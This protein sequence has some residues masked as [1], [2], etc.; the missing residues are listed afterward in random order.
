MAQFDPINPF[1]SPNDSTLD[2]Y[3][4]G[5]INNDNVIDIGDVNRLDSIIRGYLL[6]IQDDR[7]HDRSDINGDQEL[8]DQDFRLLEEY[9]AGISVYLPS[10]WNSLKTR[11][12]RIYWLKKMISIDKTNEHTNPVN[13]FGDYYTAQVVINFHGYEEQTLEYFAE[14]AIDVDQNGRFNL[15][16]FYA[17][18]GYNRPD[19]NLTRQRVSIIVGDNVFDWNDWCLIDPQWD[20]LVFIADTVEPDVNQHFVPLNN[21]MDG[22]RNIT[23][24][25]TISPLIEIIPHGDILNSN[26]G[27]IDLEYSLVDENLKN[28]W[29]SFVEEPVRQ[30]IYDDSMYLD[31]ENDKLVNVYQKSGS[32]QLMLRNGSYDLIVAAEDLFFNYTQERLRINVM[33]PFPRITIHSPVMDSTYVENYPTFHFTIEESDFARAWYSLDSGLT[34]NEIDKEGSL[35]LQ[36]DNGLHQLI[37]HAEDIFQNWSSDTLVFSIN[38]NIDN[39]G[40]NGNMDSWISIYPNPTSRALYII[41]NE[42]SDD[43]IGITIQDISGK[44]IWTYMR[45]QSLQTKAEIKVDLSDL[46]PGVY[47]LKASMI[48]GGFLMHKIIKN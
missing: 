9:V 41:L 17:A 29:Y 10:H 8:S 27:F 39:V 15:P 33:D 32:I 21:W 47:L 44:V 22:I 13:Y 1:V 7:V 3:G 45:N 11:E 12:E 35:I 48:S 40:L 25:D 46:L 43:I 42:G 20:Q 24:R 31:V 4:S 36:L 28:A 26:S 18:I 16:V 34:K 38:R 19:L 14:S 37:V 5:D 2:Y 23:R 6:I 30:M